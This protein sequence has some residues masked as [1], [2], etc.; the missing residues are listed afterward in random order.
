MPSNIDPANIQWDETPAAIAPK[1]EDIQWENQDQGAPEDTFKNKMLEY[2]QKLAYDLGMIP[3]WGV[4]GIA[5]AIGTFT[6]PFGQMMANATGRKY[7]PLRE[8]AAEKLTAVGVPEETEQYKTPGEIM[9][10]V[11]GAAAGAGAAGGIARST[12]GL[13]QQAATQMAAQ[14]T[15]QLVGAAT[16]AASQQAA[17]KAGLGPKAQLAAS[18][19]GGVL[20]AGAAGLPGA[21]AVPK[22]IPTGLAE[23]EKRGIP[24][25]T[26][27]VLPPETA[28]GKIAAR[29]GKSVLGGMGPKVAEQQAKRI[30]A[31]RDFVVEYGAEP[32]Q[33]IVDSVYNELKKKRGFKLDRY[34]KLKKDVIDKLDQ[35]GAVPMERSI[36][37]IDEEIATLAAQGKS[38]RNDTL[39]SE[40]E[41]LK[42]DIQGQG[43]KNI[44]QARKDLGNA[45]AENPSLAE[46]RDKGEKIAKRVYDQINEDMGSFIK[47]KGGRVEFD[48]WK[49][50]NKKL[51]DMAKELNVNALAT[52]L[53]KGDATPETVQK[54]LFSTNKSDL[55]LL[56]KN[57]TPAGKQN[58][59]MALI[60]KAAQK[61]APFG[62][63]E[64]SPDKFKNELVRLQ[65]QTGV[66]FQGED[67]KMLNGFLE[68]LK[69]T[70]QAG[71]GVAAPLTGVQNLPVLTS[72]LGT[73][74]GGA[75][76]GGA[77]AAIGSV[78]LPVSI[79]TMA[80]IYNSKP[81]RDLLLKIPKLQSG[82]PE[83]AKLA[84][85]LFAIMQD[86]Y[87]KQQEQKQP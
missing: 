79:G 18:L 66:F 47:E 73:V 15:Q 69:L 49:I 62:L 19:I 36:A 32:T 85:R 52:T 16:G 4:E 2:G 50:G 71:E 65:K 33:D 14:P 26:E 44:E 3:R 40:L 64:L 31:A 11:T 86:Q 20:G 80:K 21:K 17:E 27:N 70:R 72:I 67:K 51:S 28:A 77:G 24:V 82:S 8:Y 54:L 12:A 60:Q 78:A 1:A 87:P 45:L 58:A 23:A 76:G 41:A 22:S 5:Q 83:Q 84:K 75:A 43:L 34:T 7:Q 48:R 38:G 55:Q 61:A 53:K 25:F 13:T 57:L 29:T 35:S 56:Y 39:I 74:T 30:R 81:V 68:A 63:E 46:V 42:T 59:K 10:A 6:D 37:K 9:R